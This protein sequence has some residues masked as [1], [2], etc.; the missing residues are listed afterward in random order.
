MVSGRSSSA[1]VLPFAMGNNKHAWNCIKQHSQSQTTCRRKGQDTKKTCF[2][3]GL[4]LSVILVL[5]INLVASLGSKSQAPACLSI[6]PCTLRPWLSKIN[7]KNVWMMH[8]LLPSYTNYHAVK[9]DTAQ[10]P[11]NSRSEACRQGFRG[12]TGNGATPEGDEETV[13]G[14]IW[15]GPNMA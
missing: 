14:L 15:W 13:Y 8:L 2:F 12:F 11:S 10:L 5:L 9:N 4:K 6:K 3:E 7:L 1:G